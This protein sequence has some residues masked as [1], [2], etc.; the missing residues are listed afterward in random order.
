MLTDAELTQLSLH[1]ETASE[2]DVRA[3][4]EELFDLRKRRRAAREKLV[5]HGLAPAPAS[6]SR[7]HG[8]ACGCMA[9]RGR[10]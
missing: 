3:I 5:A 7:D 8:P 6:A 1:P 4:A 9:C 2:E 10:A